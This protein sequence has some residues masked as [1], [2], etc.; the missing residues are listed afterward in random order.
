MNATV[1]DRRPYKLCTLESLSN[2]D[3]HDKGSKCNVAYSVPP[4]QKV[5]ELML[6]NFIIKPINKTVTHLRISSKGNL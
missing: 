6:S 4:T 2:R 3:L 5:P 1:N